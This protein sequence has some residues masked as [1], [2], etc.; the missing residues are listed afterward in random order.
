[1]LYAERGYATLNVSSIHPSVCFM[2][3]WT[4]KAA[5]LSEKNMALNYSFS[6]CDL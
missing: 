2:V 6:N 5:I 3:Q 1:M 4:V